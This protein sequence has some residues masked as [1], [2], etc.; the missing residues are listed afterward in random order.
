MRHS[1]ESLGTAS[2]A[3]T[4]ACFGA[5][6]RAAAEEVTGTSLSVYAEGCSGPALRILPVSAV[7]NAWGSKEAD[8]AKQWV[9]VSRVLA[10][11]NADGRRAGRLELKCQGFDL[12]VVWCAVEQGADV[13]GRAG[14]EELTRGA[15]CEA[16]YTLGADQLADFA[17]G[18]C[19]SALTARGQAAAGAVGLRL[20]APMPLASGGC[21]PRA[22]SAAA[23]G[24]T[25][26]PTGPGTEFGVGLLIAAVSLLLVLVTVVAILDRLRTWK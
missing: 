25:A 5:L 6:A 16:P 20:S 21:G 10:G 23:S 24:A 8:P 15:G 13:A 3:L 11:P 26:A 2:L 18:R 17:E 19:A 14:G 9:G 7:A 12:K 22:L 1:M 4:L